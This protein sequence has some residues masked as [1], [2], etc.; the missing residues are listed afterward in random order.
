[1]RLDTS[2][3]GQQ[4][5]TFYGTLASTRTTPPCG[6][7][8]PSTAASCCSIQQQNISDQETCQAALETM[9]VE[10]DTY[11][12]VAA[13]SDSIDIQKDDVVENMDMVDTVL[14]VVETVAQKDGTAAAVEQHNAAVS[15]S[16]YHPSLPPPPPKS[17]SP[18]AAS[19]TP[20]IYHLPAGLLSPSLESPGIRCLPKGLLSLSLEKPCAADIHVAPKPT[21]R[22]EASSASGSSNVNQQRTG[23]GGQWQTALDDLHN[24]ELDRAVSTDS[25]EVFQ[26]DEDILDLEDDE[27]EETDVTNDFPLDE[28]GTPRPPLSES[29]KR[30]IAY[31][32]EKHRNAYPGL[33]PDAHLWRP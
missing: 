25:E 14:P 20:G 21:L 13:M 29:I 23:N 10:D 3:R 1:M 11:C 32:D 8:P 16:A 22:T 2:V 6:A 4:V 15:I 33:R 30:I 31:W 7:T 19:G 24:E 17:F 27:P 9:Q 18:G 28:D 12:A 26:M 5:A